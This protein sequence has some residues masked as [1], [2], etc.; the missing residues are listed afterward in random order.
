MRDVNIR[1]IKKEENA[2]RIRRLR[3]KYRTI[4]K[5]LYRENKQF[6]IAIVIMQQSHE[7]KLMNF[8]AKEHYMKV[9]SRYNNAFFYQSLKKKKSILH[10]CYKNKCY[11]NR[12][13]YQ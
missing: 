5:D 8:D 6:K 12:Y 4:A 7:K 3:N 11:E 9:Y 13:Q 10:I 2:I 1:I